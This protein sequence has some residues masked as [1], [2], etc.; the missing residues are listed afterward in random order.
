MGRRFRERETL[1]EIQIE[2]W[3]ETQRY[4]DLGGADSEI[5]RLRER[6]RESMI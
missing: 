1:V 6:P 3:V 4:R 5:Q 2:S